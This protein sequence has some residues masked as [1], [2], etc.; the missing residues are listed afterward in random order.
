MD[1]LSDTNTSEKE[2]QYEV[3]FI[4]C[5]SM[6]NESTG[7]VREGPQPQAAKSHSLTMQ[8]GSTRGS[9]REE[10]SAGHQLLGSRTWIQV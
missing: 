1:E 8:K 9:V 3:A 6:G 5:F 7:H 4:N 10:Q 2:A